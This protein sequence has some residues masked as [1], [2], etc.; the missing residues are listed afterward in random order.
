MRFL[1]FLLAAACAAAGRVRAGAWGVRAGGRCR[2]RYVGRMVSFVASV[3]GRLCV[4]RVSQ[5]TRPRRAWCISAIGVEVA[6]CASASRGR[7]PAH[8]AAIPLA[9]SE[10]VRTGE[11]CGAVRMRRGRGAPASLGDAGS[12]QQPSPTCLG[13]GLMRRRT[14]KIELV[15]GCEE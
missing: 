3:V 5:C 1:T 4:V 15:T 8:G 2:D 12:C 7:A 6:V 13:L 9:V 14:Q 10:G 11:A